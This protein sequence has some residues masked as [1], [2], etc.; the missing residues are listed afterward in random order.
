MTIEV[1]LLGVVEATRGVDVL[2]IG[3]GRQRR[4]L[5]HL[6]LMPGRPRTTE[7]VIEALWPDGTAPTDVRQSV[8]T[9]VSRLRTALSEPGS[10]V[11]RGGGYV[12]EGVS[13]DATRFADLLKQAR[14][15]TDDDEA[16]ICLGEALDLW[17]GAALEEFAH[18]EWA[19][20]DAVRLDELR[21]HASDEFGE[22]LLRLGR[23]DEAVV[24]LEAAAV[25]SPLRERTHR[26][27][28]D[29]LD[30]S[31]RTAEALRVF[32][33]YRHR[34]ATDLGL[35]PSESIRVVD[36]AIA[37]G[38]RAHLRLP[39]RSARTYELG[40]QIGSGAFSIVYRG[41][42]PTVERDVAVKVIRSELADRPEFVERF[43]AEAQLVARLEHPHIVPLYDFWREPGKA[44]LVMRLLRGGSLESRLR[45]GPLDADSVV[46]FL[47]QIGAALEAA[48]QFGVVHRDVRPAN[49]LCD[50]EGNFYL[51]DFG[52]ATGVALARNLAVES[53]GETPS[54]AGSPAYSSPEQLRGEP[55]GPW[56]DLFAFAVCVFE[57]VTGRLPFHQA[58]TLDGM[59]RSQLEDP[60]PSVHA[61]R[62][63]MPAAADDVLGIATAKV[64]A[65]RYGSVAEFVTEA[66]RVLQPDAVAEIAPTRHLE[67]NPYK[68]L[69]S[70]VETDTAD[71]VGRERL[72]N[73]LVGRTVAFEDLRETPRFLALVGPSGS[74][75][76]SVVRAGLVP[77]L[78]TLGDGRSRLITTMTPGAH[79]FE[80]LAVALGRISTASGRVAIDDL[81]RPRGLVRAIK[82]LTAVGEAD[83]DAHVL[84]VVDQFEELFT[85]TDVSERTAFLDQLAEVVEENR[86]HATVIVTLRADFFDHALTHPGLTRI[87]GHGTMPVG[88]LSD[89]ELVAAIT[90]P[91]E[92]A[93][94]T[95]EPGLVDAIKREAMGQPGALPLLQ[96]ALAELFDRHENGTLTHEA[97]VAIG[98]LEGSIASRAEQL[99]VDD[100]DSDAVRRIFIRLVRLGDG[101]EDTRRR[102]RRAELP[103]SPRLDALLDSFGAARLLTFDRDPVTREPTVEVAHEA[104]IT[105][106][107]R[108]RGWLND[109][110]DN[111]RSVE[112]LRV[113]AESW[114]RAKRDPSELYRGARLELATQQLVGHEADAERLGGLVPRCL[115]VTSRS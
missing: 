44:Y 89:D 47:R 12:L 86:L 41:R 85:M 80:E 91:A 53:S 111:L 52:I 83:F 35:E 30:A 77:A 34:L 58:R 110:R 37:E 9:A 45:K 90:V 40:E 15:A 33:D 100:D 56:S 103:A 114:E 17:R 20:V 67:A 79:P 62:A 27:L 23:F 94:A 87:L 49:I 68:G 21:A 39:S 106:W 32:H 64:P 81:A 101:V 92:R 96:H 60:L 7:S 66:L 6:A 109:D 36:A 61:L 99:L 88:A 31:G 93:G 24:E 42:Q 107:P 72:I 22:A 46:R 74:G 28:M 26:Q 112:R 84:V 10:V 43:E 8:H 13:V 104:L 95:F 25:R 65:L 38:T 105:S 14:G 48:H 16:V 82:T 63:D 97:F 51:A 71:F 1:R 57:A 50:D 98:G 11:A 113:A 70:F 59:V 3:G 102:A 75:K 4:L 76:S 29:A 55:A 115:K 2:A 19:R 18:E 54:R 5:A 78:R 73:E 108:L 69:R